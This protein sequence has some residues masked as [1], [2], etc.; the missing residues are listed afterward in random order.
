[1]TCVDE[2]GDRRQG[3]R[4]VIQADRAVGHILVR[5]LAEGLQL[6][7]EIIVS[8]HRVLAVLVGVYD[9]NVDSYVLVTG[10]VKLSDGAAVGL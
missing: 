5:C 10:V 3:W 8:V 6:G 1:M 7:D 9:Q 2:L 4:H